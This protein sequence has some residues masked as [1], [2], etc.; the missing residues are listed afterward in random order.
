MDRTEAVISGKTRTEGLEMLF[1]C[2]LCNACCIADAKI[3]LVVVT[4]AIIS[5]KAISG[6]SGED[7]STTVQYSMEN[8]FAVCEIL[9]ERL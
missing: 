7:G 8:S 4:V 6:Y 5:R 3:A 2:V 9:A 1:C